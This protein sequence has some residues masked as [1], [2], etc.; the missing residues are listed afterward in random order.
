M[1][2]PNIILITADGLRSDSLGCAGN[3]DARTPNIDALATHGIQFTNAF[4][5]CPNA[6]GG[7]HAFLTG[8]VP[9]QFDPQ[10]SPTC[11]AE[12][13]FHLPERLRASGYATVS[14]GALGLRHDPRHGAFEFS[15]AMDCD[16]LPDAY[17]IWLEAEGKGRLEEGTVPQLIQEAWHPTTWTGNEAVRLARSIPEPYFM[18]VSFPG[19]HPSLDPPVPWKHMYRPSRLTLPEGTAFA[20]TE[21]EGV[22]VD[23]R[24]VA[25]Y[26]EADFRKIL[27]AWYGTVSHLDRQIGRLLATLTAR[28][29]TNNVFVITSGRGAC[30]GYHG[31][32]HTERTPLYEPM[33]RV[34]L[35]IGGTSGQ[36]RGAIDSSLVSTGDIV[37]T[38]L[39]MH[40]LEPPPPTGSHSLA[41]QLRDEGLPHRRAIVLCDG[42]G[43]GLR[44]A[45]YKWITG[46]H[47]GTEMLFDLQVDPLERH[48]LYGERQSL[49][50]RKMLLAT[51]TSGSAEPQN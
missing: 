17:H 38:L 28:G 35:I 21:P 12:Q 18:W 49:A 39:E 33:L 2:Q 30:L 43:G 20:A 25:G 29:R 47:D 41:A 7:G 22:T 32:L 50:I 10:C 40:G 45:R 31:L 19:P 5:N 14:V 13:P 42:A 48:N 8:E 44:S 27:T 3:P 6:P 4:S 24:D 9:A 11:A 1:N 37:P 34:P 51:Q 26:S 36:R 23:P 16:G 15:E 46:G